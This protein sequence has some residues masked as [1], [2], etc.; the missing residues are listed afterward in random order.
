MRSASQAGLVQALERMSAET[1][2]EVVIRLASIALP[3]PVF[4]AG[5]MSGSRLLTALRAVSAVAVGWCLTVAHAIS[6]RAIG[7]SIASPN[8]L[9]APYDRDGAP[10]AFVAVLGWLP[11]LVM[12]IV[13]W[14]AHSVALPHF[15]G[16]RSDYS[17]ERT[18]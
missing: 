6:A 2:A 10:L 17:S 4:T 1:F 3:Y 8:K 15:R 11:S 14:L 12:V 16:E 5:N 9:L 7:I 13:A 18:R